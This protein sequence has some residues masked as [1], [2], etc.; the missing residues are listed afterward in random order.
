MINT[1]NKLLNILSSTIVSDFSSLIRFDQ[2]SFK[3]IAISE[4]KHR[5]FDLEHILKNLEILDFSRKKE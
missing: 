5:S 1:F 2:K 3:I 4:V